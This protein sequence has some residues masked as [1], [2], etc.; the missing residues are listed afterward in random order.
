M[1][2]D[3]ALLKSGKNKKTWRKYKTYVLC[4]DREQDDKATEVDLFKFSPPHMRQFHC[5]WWSF[6]MAFFVWF[7]I[8]PLVPDMKVDLGLSNNQVFLSHIASI[9]GT[10]VARLAA[11][12]LCDRYGARFMFCLTLILGSIMTA[13]VGLVQS[14]V[15]LIILRTCIGFVGA[16]F[17]MAEYWT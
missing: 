16:S 11:G 5:A 2:S 6:F 14:A 12:P 4:V 8:D 15:G 10:I 3:E 17:V 13:C 9:G 1:S 7:A